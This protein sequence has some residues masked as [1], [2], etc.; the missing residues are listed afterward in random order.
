[1]VKTGPN[2]TFGVVWA[3][4]KHLFFT[5]LCYIVY[6][7]CNIGNTGYKRKGGLTMNKTGCPR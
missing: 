2:D 7:Y 1:M 3:L 6:L 4:G 5:D